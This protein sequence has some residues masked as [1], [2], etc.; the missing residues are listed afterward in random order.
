MMVGA[1]ARFRILRTCRGNLLYFRIHII[2]RPNH[3]R[4]SKPTQTH[5]KTRKDN[6]VR[7]SQLEL[8]HETSRFLASNLL[9]TKAEV[10]SPGSATG[11]R[12]SPLAAYESLRTRL[13]DRQVASLVQRQGL[14]NL[15]AC[16]FPLALPPLRQVYRLARRAYTDPGLC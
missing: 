10:S 5:A 16:C 6:C 15:A 7:Q 4:C 11:H 14:E 13:E 8:D 3:K 1:M 12:P 2:Y 9:T